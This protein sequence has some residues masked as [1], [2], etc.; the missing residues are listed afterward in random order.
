MQ[1][2]L[3]E[4]Y[5][6]KNFFLIFILWKE[7]KKEYKILFK[8]FYLVHNKLEIK[9]NVIILWLFLIFLN[10]NQWRRKIERKI[11]KYTNCLKYWF[12]TILLFIL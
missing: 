8:L 11:Q 3:W 4:K 6:V 1:F 12:G 2:I 5:V 7:K 9:F 10:R